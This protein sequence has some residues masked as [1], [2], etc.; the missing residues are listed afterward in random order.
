VRAVLDPNVLIAALLSRKGAPAAILAR[1]RAGIIELVV[2]ESL[3][4][5]LARALA[6][7]RIR[8]RVTEAESASFIALLREASVMVEDK[9]GTHRSADPDDDY[10]LGLAQSS[11]AVLVSGDR[12][13]LQLAERLPI[14]SPRTFLDTLDAQ[15]QS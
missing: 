3:L 7:P 6:Y 12:H 4:V 11:R 2:S 8:E 13:L 10:L 14:Q 1:W 9:P 15:E 5:E